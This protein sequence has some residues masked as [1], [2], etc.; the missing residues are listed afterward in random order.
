MNADVM[1]P[2]DPNAA[3]V[4]ALRYFAATELDYTQLGG[5]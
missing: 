4:A 5:N 1:Y 2:A 3:A